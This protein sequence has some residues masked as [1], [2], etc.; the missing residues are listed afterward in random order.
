LPKLSELG[1]K[2]LIRY[3]VEHL[4]W[5]RDGLLPPG[6]DAAAFWFTG[7]LVA[8][9]DT[10]VWETD[11][12][13]R[14]TFRQVGWKAVTAAVS[15]LAAKGA[16]PKYILLSLSL[17]PSTEFSEFLELVNGAQEASKKYGATIAGGDINESSSPSI[18]VTALGSSEK[19]LSRVGAS[20]GDKLATTG[21]FGKTFAGLHAALNSRPCERELSEAVYSPVARVEEGAALA[22]C[23]GVSACIDSSDGLAES[24]HQLSEVNDV[25]FIVDS[26]PLDSS[27][28]RY[29][30][31]NNL[32]TVEAVFY[33][34]EEYELVFTVKPGWRNVVE[35]ALERLGKEVVWIGS[36]SEERG[37]Y[38]QGKPVERRGWQHFSP[39][40]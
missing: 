39:V 18:S 23:G 21:L 3:L 2:R 1:E 4:D 28:Q 24:L 37:V 22:Q 11:V 17:K 19:L 35:K 38:F 12:P 8:S 33:G 32:D 13:P 5:P 14:M 7:Q 27:A 26:L 15:D 9:V 31:D 6:D 10:L 16:R 25:G 29:C 34:G 20:P 30:V 40:R 36:V